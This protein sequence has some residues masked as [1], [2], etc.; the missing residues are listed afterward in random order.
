MCGND[1][2]IFSVELPLQKKIL[3]SYRE[4]SAQEAVVLPGCKELV[5]RDRGQRR[6]TYCRGF[7]KIAV[8]LVGKVA[9]V[10][11]MLGQGACCSV[12]SILA[13]CPCPCSQGIH[14]LLLPGY[15]AHSFEEVIE[16]QPRVLVFPARVTI[17]FPSPVE[18]LTFGVA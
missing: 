15:F 2:A 7:Q 4:G 1:F 14:G 18:F 10:Q 16:F 11:P 3:A 6:K 8:I 13:K 5:Q 9:E 17:I 12:D